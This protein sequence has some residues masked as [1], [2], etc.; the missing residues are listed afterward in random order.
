MGISLVK[1]AQGFQC[2]PLLYLPVAFL[3][4]LAWPFPE[5]EPKP[6][7]IVKT[8]IEGGNVVLAGDWSQLSRPQPQRDPV[9]HHTE[10]CGG[11]C[12]TIFC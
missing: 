6:Y 7:S 1:R 10:T 9:R 4:S 8:S 5:K 11:A 3:G 12:F 2:W